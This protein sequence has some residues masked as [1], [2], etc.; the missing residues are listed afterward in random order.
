MKQE[1]YGVLIEELC[2]KY[3]FDM[4]LECPEDYHQWFATDERYMAQRDGYFFYNGASR[5]VVGHENW[6]FVFKFAIDTDESVD[7]CANEVYIYEKAKKRGLAQYFAECEYVGTYGKCDMYVVERCDC[8]DSRNSNESWELQ[9][10]KYCAD[11]DLDPDDDA[12]REQFNDSDC[13]YYN[14]DAMLDLAATRWGEKAAR[15]VGCLLD[16]YHVNDCHCGNWGWCGDRFVLT[17]YAGYGTGAE[18]I[19]SRMRAE[20]RADVREDL[21]VCA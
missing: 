17:D 21:A 13:E 12:S 10:S 5:A 1:D 14:D 9:Y 19:T 2:T 3:N 4:V 7:Y 15:E 8:D 6:D 11:Y 20:I 16:D 18:D